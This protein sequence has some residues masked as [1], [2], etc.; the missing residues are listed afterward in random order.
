LICIAGLI[1]E[2]IVGQIVAGIAGVL[3]N[4][5]KQTP[6]IRI[7]AL[8]DLVTCR[9]RIGN[10]TT[11][12]R[13]PCPEGTEFKNRQERFWDIV[14]AK[15]ISSQPITVDGGPF[16]R[17]VIVGFHRRGAQVPNPF[18]IPIRSEESWS[19]LKRIVELFKGSRRTL[20]PE[21]LRLLDERAR[22][23][24]AFAVRTIGRGRNIGIRDRTLIEQIAD[25]FATGGEPKKAAEEIQPAVVGVDPEDQAL[26]DALEPKEEQQEGADMAILG[27]L[28]AFASGLG[29]FAASVGTALAPALAQT[30]VTLGTQALTRTGAFSP[31]PR[32]ATAAP[33]AG[34]ISTGQN[35]TFQRRALEARLVSQHGQRNLQVSPSVGQGGHACSCTTGQP[36][37]H[38][39]IGGMIAFQPRT[40]PRPTIPLG[41]R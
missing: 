38:Q 23:D 5:T 32:R 3:I 37:A 30:A 41:C 25:M 9:E 29:S 27:G 34:P 22:R 14:R 20:E 39:R 31:T 6:I 26:T 13:V 36:L 40:T 17:T 16:G 11:N 28:S 21:D 33:A 18:N 2:I 8:P 4:K 15:S 19:A 24:I 12:R 35:G 10:R 1:G 7:Q